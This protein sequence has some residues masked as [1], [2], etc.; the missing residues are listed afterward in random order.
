M[1]ENQDMK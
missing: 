1:V